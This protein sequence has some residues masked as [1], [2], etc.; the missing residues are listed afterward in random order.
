VSPRSGRPRCFLNVAMSLDGK[1]ASSRREFPRFPSRADRRMM[2]RIRARSDAVLVGSGTLRAA[3]YPLRIR[4]AGLRRERRL[5]G[6]SEQPLNILLS[7]SLAVPLRGRFFAA[8][9]TRRLVVTTQAAPRSRVRTLEGSAE[10]LVLGR[11]RVSLSRLVRELNSRGV[12]ELLLEGGGETNFDFFRRDLVDEVYLTLC[13]L[14]IG[15]AG[16]PTPV[17]GEGFAAGRF[18]RFLPVECRRQG[19]ELFLHFLRSRDVRLR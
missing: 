14:V 18:P 4:S 3:D 15:G 19:G 17:D 8:R 16:S 9:D 11:R 2:D 13:P 5:D 1:I 10:V 6:R 12:R 7:S